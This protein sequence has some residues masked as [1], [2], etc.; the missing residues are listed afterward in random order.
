MNNLHIFNCSNELA[1]ASNMRE[2]I[3]PKNILSMEHDLALL[4][5]W[6]ANEYDVVMTNDEELLINADELIKSCGKTLF[7]T[8]PKENYN[9]LC[10]R[11]GREYKPSPWGWSRA[12]A[13]KFR[14]FGV[15]ENL[16]PTDATLNKIRELSSKRYATIYIKEFLDK[17]KRDGIGCHF[18]GEQMRFETTLEI[19]ELHERTIFKSPWS[20]S[21][22][23]VF[24]GDSL[25]LP[26]I[27]EKLVGFIKRQGGFVADRY[28][29]K[30]LDFALEFKIGEN[31]E[32]SFCGYSVFL[33][34]DNGYYGS[35]IVASQDTL[36]NTILATGI[37]DDILQWV[38]DEHKTLLKKH[39]ADDYTGVIGID[40]LITNEDGIIKIHP[41]IEIN[42]R[43][44]LGIAAIEIYKQK[45]DC[46]TLLTPNREKGFVASIDNHRL[47]I[48]MKNSI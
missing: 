14:K 36:H 21:G 8:T 16:I 41:C 4:P 42:M 6:W 29:E 39:F 10:K 47:V 2:Y 31:R 40:L 13:E 34:A 12:I 3:P 43:M 7:F 46:N 45:G 11:I 18:V 37:D 28:Y 19:P 48:E 17:A 44:N 24:A 38:I 22:R 20:S 25:F 27:R 23:G 32:I 15:P 33:A 9:E 26:S 1:L 5:M 30:S 35:N